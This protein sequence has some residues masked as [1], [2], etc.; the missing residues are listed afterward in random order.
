MIRDILEVYPKTT[1]NGPANFRP[2]PGGELYD[3]CVEKY[4]LKMPQSLEEWASA[5]ILGGVR[6]PWLKKIYVNQYMWT[7]TKM[8]SYTPEFTIN[9]ANKTLTAKI[10]L[11]ILSKISKYRLKNLNYKFPIEFLLLDWYHRFVLRRVRGL[12]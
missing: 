10:A 8:A 4:N 7:S 11:L 6:P 1:I 2:Y 12:S 5:D 9:L 3:Y